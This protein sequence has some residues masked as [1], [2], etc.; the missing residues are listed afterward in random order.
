[1][2]KSVS[3]VERL[4]QN[5]SSRS[6]SSFVVVITVIITINFFLDGLKES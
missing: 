5:C 1:M 4:K 6:S 3:H 2:K